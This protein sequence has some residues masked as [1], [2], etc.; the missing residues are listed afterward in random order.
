MV[1]N[2][3]FN[4]KNMANINLIPE[5]KQNGRKVDRWANLILSLVITAVIVIIGGLFIYE[6]VLLVS[7][8]KVEEEAMSVQN[9]IDQYAEV[10][11]EAETLKKQLTSLNGLLK[12]HIYWS[13]ILWQLEETTLKNVR[14]SSLTASGN[15]VS[16]VGSAATYSDFSKQIVSFMSNPFFAGYTTSGA[17]LVG[18]E[19]GATS[20]SFNMNLQL[21][22]DALYKT[23]EEVV[24]D[25]I[26]SLE[27]ESPVKEEEVEGEA[28][29]TTDNGEEAEAE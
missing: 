1:T 6:R 21:S 25:S 4:H 9:E 7:A 29:E 23:D 12:N 13:E 8:D 15:T 22:D 20:V 18:S 27:P 19:G 24:E 11:A 5:S 17:N 14:F 2:N 10:S 16:L 3:K 28:E 26:R